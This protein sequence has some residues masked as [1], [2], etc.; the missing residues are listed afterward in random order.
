[1][2]GSFEEIFLTKL[3]TNPGICSFVVSLA[4]SFLPSLLLINC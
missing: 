2:L 4:G 3:V 1:M